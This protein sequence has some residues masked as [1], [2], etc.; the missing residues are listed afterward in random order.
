MR[1]NLIWI[2]YKANS[3]LAE[4]QALNCSTKLESYGTKVKLFLS[5]SESNPFAESLESKNRLPDLAVVLGGDG[6]VLKAARYL[7]IH[8]IP[9]LSF[10]VGGNL[11]F[12][13]HDKNLLNTKN[14]WEIVQEDQFAIERRMMLEAKIEIH[15]S[16]SKGP[17]WA[18]NDFYFRSYRDEISPTCNLAL[19]IDNEAVDTYK[20]DGLI[21]STPTGSTAYSMA[22]GGPIVHPGVES[23]TV[24]PICPMS[25]SSRSIVVPSDSRLSIKPLGGSSQRVKLWQDG[26]STALIAPGERCLI[27][28]ARHDALM[29]VIDQS[30]SYYRTVAQ[31]L[32]WAGSIV[33]S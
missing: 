15:N 19:E 31:K 28:K 27:E 10:N 3:K 24:S 30:L 13:T 4:K 2:I 22:T 32:Y 6:T 8:K 9:I 1:L 12:L 16:Q 18:L 17:Y 20:G 29:V 33:K 14:I 5:G 11:G 25:L 23:I 7:S 26:A 21:I